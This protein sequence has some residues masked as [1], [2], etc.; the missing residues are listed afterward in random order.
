MA[1]PTPVERLRFTPRSLALAVA[2]FG[3]SLF[4]L[5]LVAASTRVLGWIAVAA[6]AAGLLQI[7][8]SVLARRLPRG[9]AVAAVMLG[10]ISVIGVVT[11]G[12]TDDLARQTRAL[13]RSAPRA[14]AKIERKP[15]RAGQLA[16]DVHLARWTRQFVREVPRRLQGGTAVEAVRSAATRGVAFLVTGVLT[17][18][19]LLHGPRLAAGAVHQ[20][21]DP[22]RQA[23]VQR[24][25]LSAFHRSAR[26]IAGTIAMAVIAGLVAY[27]AGRTAEIPGHTALAVWLALWDI[28]PV[29]GTAIGALPFVLLAWAASPQQALVLALLFI[30]YQAFEGL[31]LQRA[32]E[33]RSVRVGAFLTLS[34]AFLGLELYGIGGALFGAVAIT[35]A[36]ALG[37][38]IAPRIPAKT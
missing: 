23:R 12:V 35:V 7:P 9:L 17:L 29:I 10:T 13:Q 5:R 33:K 30:G 36:V 25:A 32:L 34:A 3:V 37:D 14:A 20:I 11:Y 27:V 1:R 15:G 22:G 6:V 2:L 8:V 38:E 28:V 19:F 16:R 31:V 24:V 18:F 21:R 26:Y 4:L